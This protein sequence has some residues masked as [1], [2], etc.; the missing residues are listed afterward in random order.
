MRKRTN[1]RDTH[2]FGKGDQTILACETKDGFA[3]TRVLLPDLMATWAERLPGRMVIGIPNRD[4][5]IAFSDRDPQHVATLAR[6]VRRDA[7]RREHPLTP[8][9]LVWQAGRITELSPKH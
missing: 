8:E 9:L 5:L 7:K 3:A 1:R 6:Q 2:A 4:F